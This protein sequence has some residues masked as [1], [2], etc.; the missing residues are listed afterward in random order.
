MRETVI[1]KSLRTMGALGVACLLGV[2]A[3]QG[4]ASTEQ[5]IPIG[6]SPGMSSTYSMIGE[7]VSVDRNAGTVTVRL[8]AETRTVGITDGTRIWLDR[9]QMQQ[10]AT[11][12][13]VADLQPGRNVEI[14]YVDYEAKENADWI[15]VGIT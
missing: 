13:S 6:Q 4:Q 5:I 7:V 11:T 15:K 12:G 14:K 9:S 10:G 8:D 1:M 3:L 2:S